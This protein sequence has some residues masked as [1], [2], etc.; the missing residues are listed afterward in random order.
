MS[1]QMLPNKFGALSRN[2]FTS[3]VLLTNAFVWY[4]LVID[5]LQ[6]I[7]KTLPNDNL[8]STLV[9]TFHFAG[10]AFSALVGSALVNRVKNRHHFLILWMALGTVSSLATIFMNLTYMP[11]VL[12]LS[13][14]LGVSLGIGMP[15]CMGY[16]T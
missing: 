8:T 5:V 3:I 14:L 1:S 13:L 12:T 7:V 10:I 6:K 11:N 9:W 16:F 2:A 4:Y 15:S